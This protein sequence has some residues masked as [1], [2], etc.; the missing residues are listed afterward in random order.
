MNNSH[1]AFVSPP[2]RLTV[3]IPALTGGGAERTAAVLANYW[4]AADHQVTLI[5]LASADRDVQ[6]LDSRITRV[7]L[8]ALHESQSTAQ[9]LWN[10]AHRLRKLRRAIRASR[11]DAI[12]SFLDQMNVLTLM[13]SRRLG[14]RV[15][16]A[17]RT[18]PEMHSIGGLWSRLRRWT[19]PW[20]STLVVQT[21]QVRRRL[22]PFA[23]PQAV[24]VIP[25]GVAAPAECGTSREAGERS[26]VAMGRLAPEKGFDLLI[27]AFATLA[28]RHPSWNLLI[29]GE[30]P[31]RAALEELIRARGLGGRVMLPGWERNPHRRLQAA[32]IFV[33]SSRYEGF[34]NALLEAMACGL[35]VV[36]SDCPYGPA[37]IVRHGID[38]LLVPVDDPRALASALDRLMSDEAERR[39]LGTGAREVL[40]R[41]SLSAFF[42]KWDAVVLGQAGC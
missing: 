33:L 25:N 15:V 36:S 29:L 9:A 41:F 24:A 13:A 17:E 1:R 38:G 34:P 6:A 10:N 37:E 3:T 39:R 35:A 11:P 26:I 28:A 42:A 19:Y 31:H 2:Q 21:E 5:T 40:E 14:A 16:I 27:E 8:N 23:G 30:G 4:A 12:I 20:C 7:G 22:E 18:N 32:E